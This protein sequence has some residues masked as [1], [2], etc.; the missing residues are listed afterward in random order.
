MARQASP[1][2]IESANRAAALTAAIAEHLE[3]VSGMAERRDDLL[4]AANR[5]GV[6]YRDLMERTGLSESVVTKGIRRAL[7][8][9]PDVE[10]RVRRGPE[11]A[12][13]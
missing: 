3:T 5:A 12:P 2:G 4:L 1:E 6:G 9:H 8:R 7:E 10:R 11:P 13:V